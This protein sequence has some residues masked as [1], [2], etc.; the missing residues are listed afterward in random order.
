MKRVG[1]HEMILS[2]PT[3]ECHSESREA[4]RTGSG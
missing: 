3:P 2:D 1:R 4:K